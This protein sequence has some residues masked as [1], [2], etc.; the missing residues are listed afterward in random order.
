[1]F[2]PGFS[3]REGEFS[4]QES[5]QKFING[6]NTMSNIESI[7]LMLSKDLCFVSYIKINY[8]NHLLQTYAKNQQTINIPQEKNKI[9]Q[10][11]T[12]KN[13][14]NYKNNIKF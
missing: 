5:R 8:V 10:Q 9:C 1:M 7:I 2:Y 13:N 12:K 14:E 11:K 6:R 3:L 4:C